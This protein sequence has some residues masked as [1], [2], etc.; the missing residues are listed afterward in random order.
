MRSKV[1]YKG[2]GAQRQNIMANRR[3]KRIFALL[4]DYLDGELPVRD[5]REL[6]RHLEGCKPCIVFLE[7]LKTTVEACRR[8]GQNEK[9]NLSPPMPPELRARLLASLRPESIRAKAMA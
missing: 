6:E 9:R 4:S 8:Y 3:C 1:T 7:S 2:H 5:C